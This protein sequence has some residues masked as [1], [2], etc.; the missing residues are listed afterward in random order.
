MDISLRSCLSAGV[1]TVTAA[2][3]VLAP[4][5]RPAPRRSAG[6]GRSH[7]GAA[8][9]LTAQFNR[10]R[11][12]PHR[13]TS[14]GLARPYRRAAER[15]RAGP[16]AGVPAGRRGN[17]IGSTIKNIYN[18]VEPWVQYGF[19]LATYAVG[20]IPY[21]GWLSRADHDLLQLRR[22]HR[23]AAS[24]STSP[25]GSTATSASARA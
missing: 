20:W 18:A 9:Q 12:R 8:D 13:P 14:G 23:R 17:S 6:T 2:A 3:I 10:C 1:A 22:T 11:R 15:R 4:P 5:F 21:V 7:R 16:D 19:E 25:T 24:R